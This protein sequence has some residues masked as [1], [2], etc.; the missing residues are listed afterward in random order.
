[1]EQPFPL[2]ARRED[3]LGAVCG[4]FDHSFLDPDSIVSDTAA[5]DDIIESARLL[6]RATV[7]L[8]G[9]PTSP[10]FVLHVGPGRQ[11][12]WLPVR[13]THRRPRRRIYSGVRNDRE[14]GLENNH[15]VLRM[16]L[17]EALLNTARSSIVGS[18]ADLYV[19][20]GKL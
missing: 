1:V 2:L 6:A 19:F 8:E 17:L 7:E 13:A 14:R 16:S 10:S 4:A 9:S 11:H 5:G 15:N 18:G 3:N 12:G 20:G